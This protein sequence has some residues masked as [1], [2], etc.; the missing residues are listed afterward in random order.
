MRN[1][2]QEAFLNMTASSLKNERLKRSRAT[3]GFP[4]AS[5]KL[6]RPENVW[7]TLIAASRSCDDIA[8]MNLK[9]RGFQ[10]LLKSKGRTIQH[11]WCHRCQT[12]SC[13]GLCFSCCIK[14][15]IYLI[16]PYYIRFFPVGLETFTLCHCILEVCHFSFYQSSWL[17]LCESRKK[18]L[19]SKH[20]GNCETIWRFWN[21]IGCLLHC[22]TAMSLQG[23]EMEGCDLKG[24]PVCQ[25]GKGWT[26]TG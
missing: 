7:H 11:C 17:H 23:S 2:S 9:L 12:W 15:C 20:C 5:R 8:W 26:D 21:R 16:T 3:E 24:V 18:L 22:K 10:V 6:L 13:R 1:I 25:I 4:Q 14:S 19:T